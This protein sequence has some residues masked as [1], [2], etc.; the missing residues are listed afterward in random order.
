MD[1]VEGLPFS[2]RIKI[3]LSRRLI[4]ERHGGGK[5][6]EFSRLLSEKKFMRHDYKRYRYTSRDHGNFMQY[7]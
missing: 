6:V 7:C 2:F 1:K 3:E 5:I 4:I